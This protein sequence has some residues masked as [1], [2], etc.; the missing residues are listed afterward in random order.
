MKEWKK[1]RRPNETMCVSKWGNREGTEEKKNVIGVFWGKKRGR[2]K[3]GRNSNNKKKKT[4]SE[5]N[6]KKQN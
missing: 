6:S 5:G 4:A 3:K 2:K 1:E